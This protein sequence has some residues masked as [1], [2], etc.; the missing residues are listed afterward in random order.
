VFKTVKIWV[1]ICFQF[2]MIMSDSVFRDISGA[3]YGSHEEKRKVAEE[4]GL[5]LVR[6][7]GESS[8]YVDEEN[9]RVI[10]GHRGTA[11]KKDLSA[12]FAIMFG[13]EKH[14][15]RFKRAAR[16]EREL[17][18]QYP[19]YDFV[20]TGHSLGGSVAQ[21][22]GKSKRVSKVV[23][24]NKGSGA[25]E[26][27]RRR[28]KKQTDYVNAGDVISMTSLL[29]RGGRQVV[30]KRKSKGRRS[31]VEGLLDAHDIQHHTF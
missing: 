17:E 28:S 16:R 10:V 18:R 19:G 13:M 14:H 24:F 31:Y 29:Q 21:H 11:K 26:P 2:I 23:T 6:S 27:F 3:A 4:H 7:K 22:T 1:F 30:T 12:D 9:K 20:V 5:Q 8:A 25:A 15:P